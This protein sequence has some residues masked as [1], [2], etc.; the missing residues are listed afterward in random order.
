M[1]AWTMEILCSQ[2]SAPIEL[3][4]A[5]ETNRAFLLEIPSAKVE[6]AL[7]RDRRHLFIGAA[8]QAESEQNKCRHTEYSVYGFSG[9]V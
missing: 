6:Y 8:S 2:E 7:P 5:V 1:R 9:H 3:P 4:F